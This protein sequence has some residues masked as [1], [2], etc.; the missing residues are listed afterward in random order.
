MAWTLTTL[1]V[2]RGA[3]ELCQAI[4]VGESIEDAD[5]DMCMRALQGVIKELPLHGYSWPEVTPVPVSVTW[6]SGNSV[7]PPTDYFGAPV[8]KYTDASGNLVPMVQVQKGEWELLQLAQTATY[9]TTFYVAPDL[10][11]K[12]WPTPT[13]NPTLKLTYQG[14]IPDLVLSATPTIQ[15]QYL[16]TLQ[17]LLADEVSLKYGCSPDVRQEIGARAIYKKNLLIQW[18]VDLAPISIS[19]VD[20]GASRGFW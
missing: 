9:P 14:I 4:G 20:E 11:F 6:V 12:L 15:Q 17:Y 3:M 5:T 8:L 16:N 1:E 18:S 10:T 13:Q 19:V 2:I 7:T